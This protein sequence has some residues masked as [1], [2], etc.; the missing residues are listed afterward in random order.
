[1]HI[2]HRNEIPFFPA[3][4]G[5]LGPSCC[6]DYFLEKVLYHLVSGDIFITS[7]YVVTGDKLLGYTVFLKLDREFF[8]I[9]PSLVRLYSA[10]ASPSSDLRLDGLM[11]IIHYNDE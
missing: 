9:L 7:G 6:K 10:A 1:M 2:L 8:C 4:K 5:F 3:F 11:A